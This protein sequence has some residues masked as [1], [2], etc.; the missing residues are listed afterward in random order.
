MPI[1]VE[2]YKE[3]SDG[4]VR[5]VQVDFTPDLKS[6]ETISSVTVVEQS[7]SHWTLTNKAATT[8]TFSYERDGITYTCAIGQGIE[9]TADATGVSIAAGTYTFLVTAT[10]SD[11]QTLPY[12]IELVV[13]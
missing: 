3:I 9:F 12:I 5:L 7:T 4:A 8:A 6:A 13:I 11:S 2:D 1:T 10:T